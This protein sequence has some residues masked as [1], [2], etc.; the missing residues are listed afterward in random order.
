MADPGRV[1]LSVQLSAISDRLSADSWTLD[2]AANYGR[3]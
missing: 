2:V 1:T 3:K